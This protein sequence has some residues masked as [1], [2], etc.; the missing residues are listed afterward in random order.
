MTSFDTLAIHGG[1]EPEP[2]TGALSVPIFATSTYIQDGV[3]ELR[4]GYE[5][6]RQ[7]NPTREALNRSMAA[8]EGGTTG[9][10]F[11]SGMAAVS[12]L[13]QTVCSPG[14]HVILPD[15]AYGGTHRL[16]ASILSRWGVEH[17][18]V[19]LDDLEAVAAALRARPTRVVWCE[20]PTNPLLKVSD[21]AALSR[22]AHEAGALLVV[23]STFASSYLQQPLRLGADV[24]V[25][26][27]SK[28]LGGHSDVVCGVMVMNDAELTERVALHGK[29]LGGIAGPFDSWLVLRGI[30][31]LPVRMER[32]CSNAETIVQMLLAHPLVHQVHYP[33]LPG[34]PGHDV[35]LEQMRR[36]GGMISFQVRGG[37]EKAV[38]VCRG[39]KLWTLASSLGGVE[40]LIEHPA[41]MT[42][43]AAKGTAMEVPDDLVRLSVGLEDTDDLIDDLLKALG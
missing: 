6:S 13:L 12:T 5:Y 43:A 8:L 41:R 21:I 34:H 37:E 30:K 35:A 31:T 28:Y 40:S 18:P 38:E 27:A 25:H 20:T 16:V 11:A 23:D 14:D 26:S 24:V 2:H 39:T 19:A 22:L 9:M 15:N 42:H 4:A 32:H 7:A 3:D 36:F 17:T 29:T 33:G 10:A 1:Q